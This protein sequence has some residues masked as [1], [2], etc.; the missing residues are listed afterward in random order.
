MNRA[1]PEKRTREA[2]MAL[3]KAAFAGRTDVYGTYCPRRGRSWQV[4]RPVTDRVILDHLTGKRPFGV[5][6]LTG[7][8]TRAAAVDF[9]DDDANTPREF[10]QAL[11]GLGLPSYLER[12]K[13][14]GYHV[15][16]FLADEGV[17]AAKARA[18]LLHVLDEVGLAGTE[19]FPKQDRLDTPGDYGNFINAPLFGGLVPAGRT[20]FLHPQT[21]RPYD[22]QWSA[23][24]SINRI[25][26]NTIDTLLEANDIEL[27]TEKERA[28]TSLGIVHDAGAL[29]PCARS[30]LANGVEANQRV[31]CF[32]LAVHLHR[33]GLPFDLAV[34]ALDCWRHK[35]RPQDGKRI[36]TLEEVKA[37]AGYAYAHPYRGYGCDDDAIK[38]HC[39]VM[40]S[41]H[42]THRQ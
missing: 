34:A 39:D 9:D 14:K 11:Q 31:I 6:L 29:P 27:P 12:S 26:E 7:A 2:K 35:N 18:L 4:K 30:I 20:V 33:I 25:D 24:E 42:T 5:Y 16:L 28:V 32:R 38:P 37:Q 19:V 41:L 40:C 8:V 17:H 23:L 10:M 22:D 1:S 21:M 36:L 13:A 3:F 15:W